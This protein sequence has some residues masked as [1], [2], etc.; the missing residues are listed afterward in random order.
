MAELLPLVFRRYPRDEWGSFARFGWRPIGDELLVTLAAIDPPGAGD[1][2]ERVPNVRFNESYSLRMALAAE[3]HDLAVGVVHSH[4]RRGIPRPSDIDDDMDGY[5]ASYFEAFTGGRP[6]ISLIASEVGGK[7]AV[8]GRIQWQGHWYEVDRVFAL[9]A[10][11]QCWPGGRRPLPEI[12][13]TGRAA[14]FVS[15]YGAEAYERMRAATV[16]VVGAGGTGSAAIPVLA[17]A[18]V[19]RIIAIDPDVITESNLERVHGAYPGH[20]QERTAKVQVASELVGKID[21]SIEFIGIKGRVPQSEVVDALAQADVLL[22]CTDQHSSRLALS[23]LAYR[24]LIPAIDTGVVLEGE[25]GRVTAQVGQLVRFLPSDRCAICRGVVRPELIG[26]ELMSDEEKA[27]CKAAAAEAEARGEDPNPYWKSVP[28]I[29]TVG[30]VTTTI[31]ALAANY[32]IGWITGRFKP[33][34][35]RLQMNLVD[36]YLGTAECDSARAGD[37]TCQRVRGWS[38]QGAVEAMISAPTHW[39]PPVRVRSSMP[40]QGSSR[41]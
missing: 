1:M 4:P 33:P 19:G 25:G 29:N 13:S 41:A 30:S 26:F 37:C 22:G 34:F 5:Y 27:R 40:H 2:D 24:Y 6:Y 15:A 35:R 21:P 20:V 16:G 38:D 23:E 8:S 39:D 28:Q 12:K 14:R 9:D 32:A 10:R 3:Q 18:G 11:V 17:R 31:G 7:I 36:P